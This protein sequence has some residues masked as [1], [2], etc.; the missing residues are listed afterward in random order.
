LLIERAAG[1][2]IT[3]EQMRD[4]LGSEQ[5]EALIEALE[6]AG[7]FH[8]GSFIYA[9]GRT[10][11]LLAA[12]PWRGTLEDFHERMCARVQRIIRNRAYHEDPEQHRRCVEDTSGLVASLGKLLGATR[13]R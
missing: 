10:M 13:N 8:E 1:V 12:D 11:W 5:I 2:S 3:E 7:W 6:R 4:E 9:P